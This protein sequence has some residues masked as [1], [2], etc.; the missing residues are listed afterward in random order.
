[1]KS[2]ILVVDQ[3]RFN[4]IASKNICQFKLNGVPLIEHCISTCKTLQV[5]KC[6]VLTD[7]QLNLKGNENTEILV[8]NETDWKQ[9]RT[10][11]KNDELILVLKGNMPLLNHGTLSQL[12][13]KCEEN[14]VSHLVSEDG[15]NTGIFCF[16]NT[17]EIDFER[18][19]NEK[20]G[21]IMANESQTLSINDCL[22]LAKAE[23]LMRIQKNT[24]LM[25]SG[26]HIID[27][28]NTY[29]GNDVEI[30]AGSV[31]HPNVTIMGHSKVGKNCE[32]LS[33]SYLINAIIHDEV[34]I[35]SSKIADSEVGK[36][37]TIGPYSHLRNHTVISENV[38]IG[39]FVEFKNSNFG[40]G[41]KCAH[42]T[43]IGD[44]DVGKKVNIGCGVVTV[45]YDGAHKF[46]T[47]I[48]DGAFIGSNV[49]LIAPVTVGEKALLAAGSTITEDVGDGAMGIARARQSN[50][51]EF[52]SKY[53]SKGK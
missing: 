13:E 28:E 51:E 4:K 39:N 20:D 12:Y 18:I 42:L 35:D 53:L 52:G 2:A 3:N 17:D 38:R 23:K 40:D 44:S 31:I 7:I 33:G 27:P 15:K 5:E 25:C 30:E 16:K 1:M 19:A 50:K 22:E 37:T 47:T 26:V 41:S 14:S 43:Y 10:I 36:G 48:K 9:V 6:V 49:N 45:N 34:V 11:F 29:I 46:R 24:E 21:Q 32:I 8:V